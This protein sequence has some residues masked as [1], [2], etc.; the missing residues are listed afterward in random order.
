MLFSPPFF[1]LF[2][3]KRKKQLDALKPTQPPQ[4]NLLPST[5][6]LFE[7]K[8]TEDISEEFYQEDVYRKAKL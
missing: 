6:Y 2:L 3:Q 1:C 8:K 5:M 7:G 4:V